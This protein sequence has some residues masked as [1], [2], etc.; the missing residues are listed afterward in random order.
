MYFVHVTVEQLIH[1]NLFLAGVEPEGVTRQQQ[2]RKFLWSYLRGHNE[3]NS[4]HNVK[5]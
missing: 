4:E 2:V 1:K 5:K 3:S